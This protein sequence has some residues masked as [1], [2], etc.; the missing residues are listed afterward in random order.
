M[1]LRKRNIANKV[2]GILAYSKKETSPTIL[3]EMCNRDRL[4]VELNCPMSL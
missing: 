2:V 4:L 3:Q 1:D